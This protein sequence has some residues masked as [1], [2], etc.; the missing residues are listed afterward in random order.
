MEGGSPS[1]LARAIETDR[2]YFELGAQVEHLPGAALAWLPGLTAAAPGAVI[3]RVEHA[4]VAE[5]AGRWLREAERALTELGATTSRIYLEKRSDPLDPLF[6]GAGYADREELIFARSQGAPSPELLV[7]RVEGDAD[8]A[9]KLRLHQSISTPPDG[10][11]TSAAEWVALE[12]RKCDAGME[13]YL[14]EREGEVVGAIGALEGAGVFRL[15]NIVV[16]PAYR[17]Q[18]VGL[19]MLDRLGMIG[20]RRGIS[21][22]VVFAVRGEIGELLYRAAGMRVIGSVIEWSKPLGNED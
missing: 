22:H 12:R 19:A 11:R 4:V 6:R 16:H 7:R 21:E 9:Q 8:W 14:V 18:G 10:H 15:K 5:M 20:A 2:D 17:R 13:A 1:L 3:Q